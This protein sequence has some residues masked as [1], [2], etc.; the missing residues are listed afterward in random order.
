MSVLELAKE[1][2]GEEGK[3][4]EETGQEKESKWGKE[5]GDIRRVAEYMLEH[6]VKL[7]QECVEKPNP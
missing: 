2:E 7:E 1:L 3:E 6:D 5:R 4:G